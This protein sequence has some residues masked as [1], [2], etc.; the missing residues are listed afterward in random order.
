[1]AVKKLIYKHLN[2][3]GF[4]KCGHNCVKKIEGSNCYGIVAVKREKH[5]N[6]SD[7]RK[8]AETGSDCVFLSDLTFYDMCCEVVY[9]D[10]DLTPNE[11]KT[12]FRDA[13]IIYSLNSVNPHFKHKFYKSSDDDDERVVGNLLDFF[14]EFFYDPVYNKTGR[15]RIAHDDDVSLFAFLQAFYTADTQAEHLNAET[16]CRLAFDE[17]KYEDA[18][19]YA[20]MTMISFSSNGY[21]YAY[22]L[23]NFSE[24]YKSAKVHGDTFLKEI[25][26]IYE[27]SL[28]RLVEII[29]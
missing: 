18:L 5:A 8:S 16:L 13:D 2:T 9:S 23:E 11:M 22:T 20:K 7:V 17:G 6:I 26:D 27:A 21:N 19:Y 1:M 12:A 25:A 28:K 24:A 15:C 3:L 10:R 14:N 29:S 4:T